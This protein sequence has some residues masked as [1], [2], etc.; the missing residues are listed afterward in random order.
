[1]GFSQRPVDHSLSHSG[2]N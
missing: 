2:W 1:M